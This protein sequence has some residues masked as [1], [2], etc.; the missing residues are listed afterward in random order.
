MAEPLGYLQNFLLV[1]LRTLCILAFWPL[2]DSR[3]VPLPIRIASVLAIA[4]A[5]TPQAAPSLPPWPPSWFALSVLVLQEF[6]LGFCLGLAMRFLMAGIQM[7]GNLAAVQMGF[8]MVTLIDPQS[9]AQNAVLGDLLAKLATLLFLLSDGHHLLLM[10][11]ARSFGELPMGAT[12][13]WSAGLGRTLV[14]LGAGMFQVAVQ[15][16]APILAILFLTQVAL[17]LVSRAIPQVQVMLLSFPLTI[18]LGLLTLSLTLALAGPYLVHRFR[19]LE[20]PVSLILHAL[21]G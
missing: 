7:A 6:G 2:W 12:L 13:G 10:L 3:L 19:E 9:Q 17:G 1:G 21:K 15:L 16:G 8:G 14:A 18:A 20:Q 5:L 11:L 4:L